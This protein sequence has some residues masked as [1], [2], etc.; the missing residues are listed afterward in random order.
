MGSGERATLGMLEWE[1]LCRYLA[2]FASTSLGRKEL[3]KLKVLINSSLNLIRSSS[4]VKYLEPDTIFS[5]S[6]LSKMQPPKL[7]LP[8]IAKIWFSPNLI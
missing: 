4:H 8:V 5:Q 1:R 7:E 2:D 6:S 3:L